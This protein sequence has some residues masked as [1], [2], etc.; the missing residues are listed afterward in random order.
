MALALTALHFWHGKFDLSLRFE[1]VPWWQGVL[2]YGVT[3][4][5]AKVAMRVVGVEGAL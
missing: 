2:M 4:L 5:C 3:N 1:E